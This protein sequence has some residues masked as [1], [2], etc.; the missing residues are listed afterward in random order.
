MSEVI[1]ILDEK[2]LS[3]RVE[4]KTLRIEGPNR[5]MRR[6][7][8]QM[9]NSVIIIGRPSVTCDVWRSLAAFSIPAVLLPARGNGPV[10]YLGTGL[11][12]NAYTRI[13]QHIVNQV[14]LDNNRLLGC[15]YSR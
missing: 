6:V 1:L 3:V 15:R 5:K 14:R 13:N 10:A 7:P 4:A 11:S 12:R 8:L 2:E 9:I